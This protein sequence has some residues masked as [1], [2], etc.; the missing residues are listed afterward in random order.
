MPGKNNYKK[1]GKYD[2]NIGED[3]K[4]SGDFGESLLAYYFVKNKLHVIM[5]RTVGFD[6]II[7]D[8]NGKILPKNK[9]IAINIKSRQSKSF[10][11]R[12]EKD[13]KNLEKSSKIWGLM[14]YFGFVTPEEV[15][16]FPLKLAK[17]CKEIKTK[18]NMISFPKLKRLNSKELISFKWEIKED[19]KRIK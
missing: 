8:P 14:P 1:K 7:K 18:A 17:E 3:V 10:S 5:A 13:M 11:L 19:N 12:L 4:I 15:K 9:L 2:A 16:I 6:L